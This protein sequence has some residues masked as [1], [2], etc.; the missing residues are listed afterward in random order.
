MSPINK[1]LTLSEAFAVARKVSEARV[2]TLVFN[3][4]KRLT[5]LRGGKADVGSR[6]LDRNIL[7]DLPQGE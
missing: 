1:I 7:S 2:S 5:P 3:D 6:F 4:G